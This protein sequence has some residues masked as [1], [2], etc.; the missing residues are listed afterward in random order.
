MKV[1]PLFEILRDKTLHSPNI[2]HPTVIFQM[3]TMRFKCC[4]TINQRPQ[5]SWYIQETTCQAMH[6]SFVRFL[7]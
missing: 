1:Q 7:V 4:F 6:L 2:L 5:Y 3:R